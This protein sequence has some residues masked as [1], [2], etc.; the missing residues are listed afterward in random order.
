MTQI[1]KHLFSNQAPWSFKPVSFQT[2]IFIRV[3]YS[4]K[5][6]EWSSLTSQLKWVQS[7]SKLLGQFLVFLPSQCWCQKCKIW[8]VNCDTKTLGGRGDGPDLKKKQQQQQQQQRWVEVPQLFCLTLCWSR[9]LRNLKSCWQI[10]R[11]SC[12]SV[13]E[14]VVMC[15]VVYGDFANVSPAVNRVIFIFLLRYNH[16][17]VTL[18]ISSWRKHFFGAWYWKKKQN[19]VY[20]MAFKYR[21][22]SV[23]RRSAYFSV[24]FMAFLY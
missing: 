16:N 7:Q 22:D 6:P 2:K 5:V 19:W 12:N 3:K 20:N 14:S 1:L 9:N 13:T 23:T 17:T 24:K 18:R 10:P 11:W 8:W 21:T 15:R 4:Q